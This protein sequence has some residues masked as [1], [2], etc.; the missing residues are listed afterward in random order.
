MRIVTLL[1]A[2]AFASM[3]EDARSLRT[4]DEFDL[5]ADPA[6]AEWIE[7]PAVVFSH[8]RYGRP[9][10]GHR[11]EVRSRWT[12][13]NLYL[14]FVCQYEDFFFKPGPPAEG[15]TNGLWDWDVAEVFV[16]WDFDR[17]GRY[18]EFEVS[19]RGEWVD[20]DISPRAGDGKRVDWKWDS[21]F[22]C[23][24]RIDQERK[25][26]YAEMRI[27]TKS[28]APWAPEAGRALRINFYRIQGQPRR[29]LAWQP[30]WQES[31][32][33]PEAFGRIVLE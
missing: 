2:L 30:V 4:A 21:G 11:T 6:R 22:E 25:V 15:E 28:I 19:P 24:T 7:A 29:Y 32:H 18:K 1:L 33:R 10:P 26:W 5:S 16:G 3:A 20:L 14:L 8:D 13:E 23:K 27:P 12:A 9:V 31:F 17:T